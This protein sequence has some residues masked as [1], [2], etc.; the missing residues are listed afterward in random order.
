MRVPM[1]AEDLNHIRPKKA[2]VHRALT[3]GPVSHHEIDTSDP[4][5]PLVW[6]T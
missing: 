1:Q 3:D 5:S 2:K 4:M 6:Q